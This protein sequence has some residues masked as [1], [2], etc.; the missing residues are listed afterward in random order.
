[1]AE[2]N[3]SFFTG[4]NPLGWNWGYGW[5]QAKSL[6]KDFVTPIGEGDNAMSLAQ[7]GM[8]L[9]SAVQQSNQFQQQLEEAR[10]QYEYQ[11]NNSAAN[12]QNQATNWGNQALFHLQSLYDFNQQAGMN[13]ASDLNAAF[14]Q[15]NAA[16]NRINVNN[17]VGEQQNQIQKYNKLTDFI[18]A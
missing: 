5:D 13:R 16:G 11:K 6:A 14:N 18:S 4:Y 2:N 8:G 9:Y 10:K 15:V 3:N 12:F 17:V 1:M 7:L